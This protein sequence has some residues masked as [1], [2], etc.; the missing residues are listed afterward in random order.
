M[1]EIGD[2]RLRVALEAAAL[3]AVARWVPLDRLLIET[4]S[5]LY[6]GYRSIMIYAKLKA[7]E[8]AD[9]VFTLTFMP[10]LE[11]LR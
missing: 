6:R 7:R 1:S 4:D 2:R 5:P 10:N 11:S 8:L 3:R 9:E